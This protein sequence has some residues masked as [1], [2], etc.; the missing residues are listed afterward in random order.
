MRRIGERRVARGE[1]RAHIQQAAR[2]EQPPAL[3]EEH[4]PAVERFHPLV[5]A[6]GPAE[7]P[8]ARGSGLVRDVLDQMAAINHVGGRVVP[9]TAVGRA[10]PGE[11][12]QVHLL[13]HARHREL[14]HVDPTRL[15]ANVRERI[16]VR[17]VGRGLAAL[18]REDDAPAA[19]IEFHSLPHKIACSRAINSPAICSNLSATNILKGL[20]RILSIRALAARMDLC[21]S[22]KLSKIAVYLSLRSAAI[23]EFWWMNNSSGKAFI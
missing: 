10:Q 17:R 12:K 7:L 9:G 15:V 21:N 22:N 2:L 19:K 3:G 4:E 14:V 1:G 11:G 16:E 8:P 20:S 6:V 23:S 18:Q 13:V 5:V